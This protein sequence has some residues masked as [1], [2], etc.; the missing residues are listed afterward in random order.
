VLH[1]RGKDDEIAIAKVCC[2]L[3]LPTVDSTQVPRD[4]EPFGISPDT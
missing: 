1:R 4:L 3:G 2:L